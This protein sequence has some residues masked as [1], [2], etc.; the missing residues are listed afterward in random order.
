M[1]GRT[2]SVKQIDALLP[3]LHCGQCDYPGCRPYAE[4]LQRGEADINQ[5]PP[6]GES[7]MVELAALLDRPVRPIDPAR[8]HALPA[9]VARI[10]EDACIG[11][12]KCI[13]ACPVDAILGAAKQMHT[14]IT[15]ECTGCELCMPV[16]PVDCISLGP[17]TGMTAA[18]RDRA[19]AHFR[20]RQRRLQQQA[21]ARQARRSSAD[22]IEKQ[23]VISAAVARSRARHRYNKRP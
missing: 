20:R 13:H 7:T 3:Q 22:R 12:V 18:D 16:C 17:A 1:P 8:G 21:A 10:D 9:Q 19:R 6:G 14:V 5:C 11:C 23:R 4:A 15:A 2:A